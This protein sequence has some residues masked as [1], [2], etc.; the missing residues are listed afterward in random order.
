MRLLAIVGASVTVGQHYFS[1]IKDS[2]RMYLKIA[3]VAVTIHGQTIK[4]DFSANIVFQ[5]KELLVEAAADFRFTEFGIQ[6][7]RA[8]MGALGNEDRFSM[9]V[10][11]KAVKGGE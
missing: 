11:L 3:T 1:K 5:G 7:Y 2:S 8:L 4:K 10:N 9:L 6:P